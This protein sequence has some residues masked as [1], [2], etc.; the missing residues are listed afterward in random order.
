M[1]TLKGQ[2]NRA[3]KP[4]NLIDRTLLGLRPVRCPEKI[5]SRLAQQTQVGL[6]AS[7]VRVPKIAQ[8]FW[9]SCAAAT[10]VCGAAAFS[11]H[12]NGWGPAQD[13]EA[14]VAVSGRRTGR[15]PAQDYEAAVAV[16][17]HPTGRRPAQDYE[18]AVAVAG[19][20]PTGRRPAQDYE[21][22][23]AFSGHPAG[24]RPALEA[25]RTIQRPQQQESR[26]TPPRADG[27][28][29]CRGQSAR[30]DRWRSDR[31]FPR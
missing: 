11:G 7:T 10:F 13:Y 8:Q 31:A 1:R 5:R 4:K 21:T 30:R 22:A 17:G 16:A 3:H 19:H 23:T 28:S 29:R 12:L 26:R 25:K 18:A 27:S 6:S 2:P 15:R 9:S 20:P 24:R 14:A